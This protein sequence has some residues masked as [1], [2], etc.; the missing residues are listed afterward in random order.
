MS[1]LATLALGAVFALVTP[2]IAQAV[3]LVNE[4]GMDHVVTIV[5]NGEETNI[6]VTAGSSV[7]E[8]CESCF[9]SIGDSDPVE[10]EGDEEIIVRNGMLT[11]RSG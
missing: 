6:T 2:Q 10:A 1:K 11:K 7:T 8:V 5:E 4:D 9:L 3:D